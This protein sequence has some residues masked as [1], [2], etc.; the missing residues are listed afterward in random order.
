MAI[1]S[2]RFTING[3]PS[4]DTDGNC[5]FDA[6][7]GQVLTI[8]L[9]ANPAPASAVTYEINDP[10]NPESP[11]CSLYSTDQVFTESGTASVSLTNVNGSVNITI[12]AG[13]DP[14]SYVLRA[15]TL[16]A[17][18]LEVFE[19]IIAIRTETDLRMTVPGETTQY[20]RRGWSDAFNE[21]TKALDL[22]GGG[23]GGSYSVVDINDDGL[24][25]EVGSAVAGSVFGFSGANKDGGWFNPVSTKVYNVGSGYGMYS[26]IDAAITAVNADT[27]STSARAVIVIWPGTYVSTA[28]Y[29]FPQY[30]TVRGVNRTEC[31]LENSTS[32]LVT[33]SSDVE[34]SNITVKGHNN[35]SLVAFNNGGT[36]TDAVTLR[37]I[38]MAGATFC[39]Q[40]FCK[41][42]GTG[43]DGVLIKDVLLFSN[44]TSGYTCEFSAGADR[45]TSVYI[46]DSQMDTYLLTGTGGSIRFV[47]GKGNRIIRTRVRGDSWLRGISLENGGFSNVE[48]QLQHCYIGNDGFGGASPVGIHGEVN[49]HYFLINTDAENST[50]SGT[51]TCRNSFPAS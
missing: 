4:E 19:R 39:A 12:D 27:P 44:R 33:L 25:P 15:T 30:T 50:T 8:T 41:F 11:V 2:A 24:A 16:T 42:T 31:I 23:G 1:N 22:A 51:R 32:D 6:T 38:T 20:N 37:S 26:T 13:T 47:G 36:G 29:V 34:I 40:Q 45:Y 35:A 18:G 10:D 28:P 49:T 3:T 48:C 14:S 7:A 5:G 43:W 17:N 21:L 9:E 46:E